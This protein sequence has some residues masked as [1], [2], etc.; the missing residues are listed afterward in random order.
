MKIEK[1]FIVTNEWHYQIEAG[2]VVRLDVRNAE[3]KVQYFDV[4]GGV[5]E[6]EAQ[7]VKIGPSSEI[8]FYEDK[9]SWK[10]AIESHLSKAL[11]KLLEA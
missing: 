1:Y 7:F 2:Q 8:E 4:Y 3:V 9:Q 10:A 11:A 5:W 6:C